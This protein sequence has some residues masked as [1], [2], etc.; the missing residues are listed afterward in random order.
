MDEVRKVLDPM[1]GIGY[2]FTQPIEMRVS[3]MI[4]G[5]RGDLAVKIYGPDLG[6]LSQLGGKI[7]S[8]L[9]TVQGNQDVYTVQNDGVQYLR[10]E[11]DRLQA[12]RFGLS[13]EAIQDALRVQIEGQQAGLVIEGN[14]RTPI[15]IRS[16]ESVRTSPADFNAVRITTPDGQTHAGVT[17]V[18]A[19]PLSAPE[20]GLSLVG[21]DGHELAWLGRL[22]DLPEPDRSL[23]SEEL[24]ARELMPLILRLLDVSTFATPSTWTVDTDRGRTELVL[25]GEDDIRRLGGGR[26]LVTSAHGLAFVVPDMALSTRHPASCSNAFSERACATASLDMAQVRQ[27]DGSHNVSDITHDADPFR[28]P[29]CLPSSPS[30]PPPP[31]RKPP[32][33]LA[34]S[35]RSMC[36]INATSRW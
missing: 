27:A 28:S 35:S 9:K 31:P 29:P 22:A 16:D 25:K 32:W 2:S 13:V 21:P 36:W 3:E 10:V 18:R 17:P 5:V 26:L 33:P 23:V 7:E 1:P 34:H 15:L 4:I 11:I 8:L 6:T 19:F 30:S 14:Q 20:E 12:G 24:T